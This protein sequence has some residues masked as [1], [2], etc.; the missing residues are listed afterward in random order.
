MGVL[1]I[2]MHRSGTSLLTSC[3]NSLGLSVGSGSLMPAHPSNPR[4]FWESL[5]LTDL[6]DRILANMGG[7]WRKPPLGILRDHWWESEFL[8]KTRH[9]ATES[10]RHV[11]PKKNWIW[12]DPRNCLTLPFWTK[13]LSRELLLVYIY[14]NPLEVW[15]SL[16]PR[17][18]FSCKE[19]LA[20]W[21]LY[22]RVAL[23]NLRGKCVY[24]V[25]H[26]ELYED[27][28]RV[29]H[30]LARFLAQ[31]DF[32]LS[33]DSD[34]AV[35]RMFDRRLNHWNVS[36]SELADDGRLSSEQMSLF[37]VLQGLSDTY[38]IFP[39]IPACATKPDQPFATLERYAY[40]RH[41]TETQIT[42][43]LCQELARKEQELETL[44]TDKSDWKLRESDLTKTI[45]KSREAM[46]K[47][48]EAMQ[49]SRAAIQK[50]RE[51][52]QEQTQELDSL[53]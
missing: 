19:A 4:G 53:K 35:S 32:T 20:L 11:F 23:C 13:L 9:E 48:R 14:R 16:Q 38:N 12:K 34:N 10:L 2:G 39:D 7:D 33:N 15:K 22:N 46:Q 17:D 6:N 50:L 21:E 45:Q 28:C 31:N 18:G 1:V 41:Q 30:R 52:V 44:N 3:L 51:T 5:P 37:R 26:R 36:N 27:P 8:N 43:E 49:K 24:V 29:V 40:H 47:S 25:R 42:A